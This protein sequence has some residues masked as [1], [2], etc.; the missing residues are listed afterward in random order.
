ML[1]AVSRPLVQSVMDYL[2]RGS[3]SLNTLCLVGES[4]LQIDFSIIRIN[5]SISFLTFI[6]VNELLYFQPTTQLNLFKSRLITRIN[7][8][9]PVRAI[10]PKL[11][12]LLLAFNRVPRKNEYTLAIKCLVC[13]IKTPPNQV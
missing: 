2:K 1:M 5:H 9:Q 4:I 3:L 7:S 8:S 6:D 10:M 12:N 11:T 13:S